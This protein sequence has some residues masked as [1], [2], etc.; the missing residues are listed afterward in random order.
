MNKILV[1]AR[2]EIKVRFFS[3]VIAFNLLIL[4]AIVSVTPWIP[5][6]IDNNKAISI[7]IYME[8]SVDTSE[9][10]K[11]QESIISAGKSQDI[12]LAFVLGDSKK[13]LKADSDVKNLPLAIGVTGNNFNIV[14]FDNSQPRVLAFLNVYSR[15]IA[16]NEYLS[17]KGLSVADFESY[18]GAHSAKTDLQLKKASE[19]TSEQYFT[20]MILSLLLFTLIVLASTHLVMG[21]V[22]E[23]SSHVMEIILYSIRPRQLL[24]GKLAGISTFIFLQF[25]LL[26][27]VGYTSASFAG[28]VEK[29]HLTLGS[30][31]TVLL[32][33]PPAFLF[34]AILYAALGART[35]RTEEIGAVQAPLM[36]LTTASLYASVF[37]VNTPHAQWVQV[38][39]YIPPF[40]FF[41]ES[42]RTL[43]GTSSG[44]E[45]IISWLIAVG[46]TAL[47]AL[48][49]M[50]SFEKRVFSSK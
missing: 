41:M 1:I 13:Q 36:F 22:E 38:M 7:G 48:I 23:K 47:V 45:E 17:A 33:F 21:V 34:F 19:L 27:G 26:I 29:A 14:Q 43:L 28:A 42:G 9:Y 20:S 5:K 3:K 37:S 46:A 25:L 24:M 16:S 39:T 2:H 44:A 18:L 6:L 30:A 31:A 10:G 11:L 50:K 35:S 49:G 32:W 8:E 15:A 12:N 4:L 40:S